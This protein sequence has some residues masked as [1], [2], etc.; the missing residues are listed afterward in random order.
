[1]FRDLSLLLIILSHLVSALAQN[2]VPELNNAKFKIKNAI[3]IK[4]YAFPLNEVR[5]LDSPFKHAMEMDGK[6]LLSLEPDRLLHRFRKNAGLEP[7][8]AIYGGWETETISGHT[9]GHYLSACSMMFASTGDKQFKDRVIY[10]VDE[11]A[12]WQE[13]KR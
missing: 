4:A 13:Q 6:W 5:L 12:I 8:A 11:L 10:V 3:E 9:L 1:M 2:Y 7:K